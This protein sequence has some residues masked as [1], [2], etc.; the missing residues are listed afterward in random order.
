[1]RVN[2]KVCCINNVITCI[3]TK[4]KS[5][6]G[7]K[8]IQPGQGICCL[9]A[10]RNIC[11]NGTGNSTGLHGHFN[12]VLPARVDHEITIAGVYIRTFDITI[13]HSATALK[14]N[15]GTAIADFTD[16][17]FGVADITVWQCIRRKVQPNNV[18]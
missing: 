18:G 16:Q 5:L 13:S 15:T 17:K 10:G 2:W 12:G 11:T 7:V 9:R 4:H 14:Q 1:M 3:A 6:A 8:I